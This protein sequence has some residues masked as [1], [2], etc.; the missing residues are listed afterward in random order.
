MIPVTFLVRLVLMSDSCLLYRVSAGD[1]VAVALANLAE[2]QTVAHEGETVAVLQDI[3]AGHKVALRAHV[4]GEA[5]IKYSAPIGRVTEDIRPGHWVHSHNLETG[6]KGEFE[7][8]FQP[9][10]ASS[11]SFKSD[12]DR[13]VMA[14]RRADGRVA[15]R[16]EIWIIATVSCVSRTVQKLAQLG[17]ARWGTRIDGIHAVSHPLGCS[18]LGDD[19][20]ATRDLLAALA[21]HPHAGAVLLVGLGCE[22][23]QLDPLMA[24]ITPKAEGRIAAFRTQAVEDELETGMALL[25]D[26]VERVCEDKRQV[27]HLS[28][29]SLGL[30]C[31]GSDGYSGLT[32]NPL[33]GMMA[34]TFTGCGGRAIL[35]EIPEIFGAEA[36]LLNRAVTED[37]YARGRAMLQG[38]RDHFTSHGVPVYENPSPGNKAGGIT[39]LEEKS[40]GAVQKGG[41]APLVD[42]L[43]YARPVTQPGLSL[44]EAPG[45]D[46]VSST[47]LAAAGANLILFST[48][49]GTPMGFMVP[50]VKIA[51]NARLKQQKPHWIDFDASAMLSGLGATV[52]CRDALLDLIVSVCEGAQTCAERNDERDVAIWKRG[53]TL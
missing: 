27:C 41:K 50:T 38:F 8:V 10:Q 46:A 3:P 4:P 25:A 16:N 5:V 40:L 7:G 1:S 29:L 31:G 45:N 15:I 37:V 44:I 49:R 6:L 22:N 53:V 51:S 9:D 24:R 32:A 19:L 20:S 18:Q 2:G 11:L 39:T 35:T 28:D 43:P 30:K 14:Y 36:V 34:E 21:S 17:M 47:A 48:G 52:A 13:P 26:L 23:N 42:V 12:V 33:I